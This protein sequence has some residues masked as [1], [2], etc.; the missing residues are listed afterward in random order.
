MSTADVPLSSQQPE[1]SQQTL[2]QAAEWFALLRSG[3]ATDQE[4]LQWQAWL[5]SAQE[6][7]NAW[8]Y[9]ERI[10]GRF[11]PVQASP[12]RAAAA[13]GFGA[14]NT[15]MARR[16]QVLLGLGALAGGGLAGWAAF[17]HTALPGMMMAWTADY[18]TGTGEVRDVALPDGTRVWLSTASAFNRDYSDSL[19]RLR[20][21]AGEILI[22][23][24]ADPGRPF[25]VDTPQGRLRALG[26]RFTVRLDGDATIVSVFQGAVEARTTDTGATRIVQAGQQT[27]FDRETVAGTESADPAREAWTRGVLI[28]D[29][30]PLADVLR[31]LQRYRGGHLGV[32]PEVAHLP[33]VGSYP[34]TDPDRALS[35]LE[36]I[37]PIRVKRTLSWW[38]SVEPKDRASPRG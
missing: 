37:L 11:E 10:S 24:A 5:D 19:R 23:T 30:T 32:A 22:Q 8:R 3:R 36:A 38:V 26:T 17:R 18:R 28:A 20:L 12:N 6:H 16:R 31:E 25:V 15:R 33:V 9:V 14:A 35:M 21:V 34:I 13:A 2:E 7:C 29:N 27:R 4:R 1:P